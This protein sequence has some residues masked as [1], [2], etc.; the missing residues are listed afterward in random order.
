M[1]AN[2][3]QKLPI[4]ENHIEFRS[5]KRN[6]TN[7]HVFYCSNYSSQSKKYINNRK[8][9]I[10][11]KNEIDHPEPLITEFGE[12]LEELKAE[13]I[14]KTK[15]EILIKNNLDIQIIKNKDNLE[16]TKDSSEGQDSSHEDKI[17]KIEKSNDIN[18][19]AKVKIKISNSSTKPL[20]IKQEVLNRSLKEIN[21]K[22]KKLLNKRNVITVNPFIQSNYSINDDKLT[23][24]SVNI[25]DIKNN[26]INK[27]KNK[28]IITENKSNNKKAKCQKIE[29]KLISINYLINNKNYKNKNLHNSKLYNAT[30]S[31]NNLIQKCDKEPIRKLIFQECDKTCSNKYP[32]NR[33]KNNSKNNLKKELNSKKIIY[34][35]LNLNLNIKSN[36]NLSNIKK[37]ANTEQSSYMKNI[38]NNTLKDPITTEAKLGLL[39]RMS[40]IK[41]NSYNIF[42]NFNNTKTTYIKFSKNQKMKETE[43]GNVYSENLRN[44]SKNCS[45]LNLIKS[46]NIPKV[47][48]SGLFSN[49]KDEK[50]FFDKENKFGNNKTKNRLSSKNK[51][52]N[53]INYMDYIKNSLNENNKGIIN[54]R[55]SY[56]IKRDID[57]NNNLNYCYNYD[58]GYYY[59]N[60][61]FYTNIMPI[62]F[63]ASFLGNYN[64]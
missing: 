31:Y 17:N 41:K 6:N 57:N 38:N 19:E 56:T 5:R 20:N 53:D 59:G 61:I 12:D 3:E 50:S 29:N 27:N 34:Q 58:Y 1:Q 4:K 40:S 37:E 43:K 60:D 47:S 30:E 25:F 11:R 23:I 62:G 28:D 10:M 35:K 7:N 9:I 45:Q 39:N 32:I 44:F 13:F 2:Q 33:S 52:G 14:K 15:D 42:P 36:N 24:Y 55:Y 21:T 64:Y 8:K 26:G 16:R 54:K 18:S 49:K 51:N 48:N 22:N 63:N 46:S